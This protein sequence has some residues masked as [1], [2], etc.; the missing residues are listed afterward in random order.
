MFLLTFLLIL[1][2]LKQKF[3]CI[4]LQLESQ[5]AELSKACEKQYKLEQELAFHKLDAKFDEL[6]VP[7]GDDDNLVSALVKLVSLL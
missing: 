6:W 5:G 3:F 4:T 1:K 7:C 2:S